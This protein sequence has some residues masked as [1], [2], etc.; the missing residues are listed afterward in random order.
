[1]TNKPVVFISATSDLCSARD[2]VGKILYAMGYEP[3]W[4]DIAA[5]D[6]GELLDVLR[7][8]LKPA[9]LV[10][11]LVGQRYGAEPPQPTQ[12][13]GRVSYTQFEA[14]EAERLGKKVIYH[15]LD[16]RFPIDPVAAEPPELASLQAAYLERLKSINCLRYDRITDTSELELS[17]R[18]ISDELATLRRQ[19]DRR[20]R[21]LVLL[22]VAAV[23]GIAA[24]AA[25]T[26]ALFHAT[27]TAATQTAGKL[28]RQAAE[29]AKLTRAFADVKAAVTPKPLAAGQT[30]PD[31][32]PPEI[33]VK[34]QLL[35]DRG[36]AEQRA[37][38]MIALKQH[39][40]ANQLIQQLKRKAGNPID[41]AFQLLSMEGD[42]WYQAGEPDK[43]LGPYEQAFA[44]KP[45]DFK[46]HNQL[47]CALILGRDGDVAARRLRAIKVSEQTLKLVGQNSS[48]WA[49][50]QNNIGISWQNLPTG[51]KAENVQKAIAAYQ[52]ALGIYTEDTYPDEWAWT[53]DNLGL[54]WSELPTG[55]KAENMQK[56]ITAFEAALTVRTRDGHPAEFARTQENLGVAWS[57]LPTGNQAENRKKAIA[58]C[59]AGLVVYSNG[60]FPRQRL[61]AET[62]LSW[63]QLVANDFGGALT[64]ASRAPSEGIVNLYLEM[65]RAH[66][67][68]LLRRSDEAKAIYVRYQG[69]TVEE[70][71]RTWEQFVLQDLDELESHGIK[72]PE[73]SHLRELLKQSTEPKQPSDQSAAASPAAP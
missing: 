13:F 29:I 36:N 61:D 66:A 1:M 18:R 42:N 47:V 22:S 35:L 69:K 39:D 16:N 24:V 46:A 30:H 64:T 53:Q 73:F 7:R 4:Q 68:L 51:D 31:P 45:N 23:V 6:G 17:I 26:L 70:T 41:E 25:L 8:R 9:A 65:N 56:A 38:G 40:A 43:A 34:A 58:A 49:K 14:L 27:R 10:I 59:Q 5:T 54:A 50:T 57:R 15:C 63:V 3:V 19:A 55:S 71:G 52:A 32:V 62:C 11:Q 12:E 72:S 37:L 60:S 20:Q 28:D 44:L 2:L 33:L 67:L 48:E 21:R